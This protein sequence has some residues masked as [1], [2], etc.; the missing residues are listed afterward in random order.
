MVGSWLA[1]DEIT[2]IDLDPKVEAWH[3]MLL[4]LIALAIDK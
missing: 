2:P 3:R 4:R 1:E